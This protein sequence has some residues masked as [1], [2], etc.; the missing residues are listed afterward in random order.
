MVSLKNKLTKYIK[1]SVFTILLTF[2]MFTKPGRITSASLQPFIEQI[3][4]TLHSWTMKFLSFAGKIRLITSVIYGKVNFWSAVFVLPK[5][6]YAKIDSLCVAFLWKNKP[7]STRGARV[8]WIDICKPKKEG[9][10]GIRLLGDFELVFR[11]KHVW[12]YFTNAGSL[13]V[14]WLKSNVFHRKPFWQMEDSP[15]LSKAVRSLIETKSMLV[16]FLK[17]KMGNGQDAMF[18]FDSWNDLGPLIDLIGAT[19]PRQLRIR[20]SASVADATSNGE[21]NLPS[22]RSPQAE[23]L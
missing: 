15:R 18:W 6:V 14:S 22:A 17:C 21:W 3:T 10:L 7:T 23:A 13:W 1:A 16:D 8:A 9:G 5:S 20:L 4:A 2:T 12:N 11:L 19:G